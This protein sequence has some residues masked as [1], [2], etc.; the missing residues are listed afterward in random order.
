MKILFLD[1]DGVFI[2]GRAYYM[3]HQSKPIVTEFDPCVVGMV[4]RIAETT[5]ARF[6]I[7]SSWLR[8][9]LQFLSASFDGDTPTVHEWMIR[10]GL[11]ERYFHEDHSCKYR[12]SGTRWDA[13]YDWN[14]S[15]PEVEEYRILEDETP[16]RNIVNNDW[17]VTTDFDEG[18][19]MKQHLQILKEWNGYGTTS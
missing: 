18:L 19:T 11:K 7:H 10:Q 6:V 12:F 2:P 16:P 1:I 9:S 8:S 15:H 14:E 4:N 5:G 13:I 17:V 3:A